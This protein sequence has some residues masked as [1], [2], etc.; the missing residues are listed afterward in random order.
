MPPACW[1]SG[2]HPAGSA[3][4]PPPQAGEGADALYPSPTSG[5][6]VWNSQFPACP[7]GSS[8]VPV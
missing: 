8:G 5:H 7:H 6:W 1:L 2:P 3:Y 4:H